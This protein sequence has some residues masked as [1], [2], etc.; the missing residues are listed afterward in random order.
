MLKPSPT[1]HEASDEFIGPDGYF[2]LKAKRPTLAEQP[3]TVDTTLCK[4]PFVYGKVEH[5]GK[6]ERREGT[7]T[8]RDGVE[9]SV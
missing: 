1:K 3:D 4:F 2:R 8:H 5:W 7:E 9:R 6:R